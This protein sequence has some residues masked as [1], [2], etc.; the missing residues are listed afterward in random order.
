MNWDEYIFPVDIKYNREF[1]HNTIRRIKN[2]PVYSADRGK[3]FFSTHRDIYFP[4][5]AEAIK[6]K[7]TLLGTT[8]FSFSH[9]PPNHETGWHSDQNRGCTLILPIDDYPHLIRFQ[10]DNEY[11][12]YYYNGP[13]LTNA[14]TF[15]NG[16]NYTE[17]DR[18]NLLFHYDR[19]YH[20][21]VQDAKNNML[22]TEWVQ[23]YNICLTFD[24]PM[25][26]QYFNTHNNIELAQTVITD[27][28]EIAL[29]TDKFVVL[30]GTNIEGVS[31]ITYSKNTQF[32]DIINAIKFVLDNPVF[33]KHIELGE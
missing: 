6:I 21:L 28:V 5:N 18:F 32:V 2:W 10:I 15:H 20:G 1:L 22:V 12:D 8:T 9:I 33:I 29:S 13:V 27:N 4:A 7:N 26:Q 30:L 17:H 19:D 11:H 16:I 3:T 25:L 14:K 31:C 23:D 24:F